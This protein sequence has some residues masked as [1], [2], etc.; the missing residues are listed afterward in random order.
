[1]TLITIN[2]NESG[3][4]R[5][6]DYLHWSSALNVLSLGTLLKMELA[7]LFT[8]ETFYII[9]SILEILFIYCKFHS[10]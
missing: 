2:I 8:F 7:Y 5:K 3:I 10:E 6:E 9:A 4:L 1:M